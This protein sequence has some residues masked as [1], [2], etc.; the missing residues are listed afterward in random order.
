MK[1]LEGIG[2]R[3]TDLKKPWNKMMR[4]VMKYFIL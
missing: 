1:T 2:F 4:W 3:V